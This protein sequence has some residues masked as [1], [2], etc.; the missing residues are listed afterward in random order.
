MLEDVIIVGGGQAALATAYYLHKRGIDP[1]ILDNQPAPGGSWR[2]VWPSLTLFSTPDFSNLPGIQMPNYDGFPPASHVIDYLSSYEKRYELRVQRPV[3][4]TDVSHDGT[5]HLTSDAGDFESRQLIAATGNRPFVPYYPGTTAAK[6]W[7][8]ANYPGPEPFEGSRVA[9]VGA[10]N[11]GA[12][13]ASELVLS[14]IDTTWFTRH[15][16]RWMPND[17]DG[18][19]LFKRYRQGSTDSI[20]DIVVLP[21]VRKARDSGALTWTPMFSSLDDVHADH[22]IWCTGFRPALG[23]FRSIDSDLIEFVGYG[24]WVGPGA[25]T[26]MGVGPFAKRAAER[27]AAR[28]SA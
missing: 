25:A 27:V 12:Q 5:F 24:D 1:L 19:V 2:N 20:G 17:V 16:P 23:P 9:V 13:I 26:I 22:L 18:R 15:E 21:P 7:H 3:A 8:S 10:A 6:Q 28:L 11:S 4:V 14:N